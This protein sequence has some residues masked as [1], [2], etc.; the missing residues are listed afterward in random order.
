MTTHIYDRQQGLFCDMNE[1]LKIY[2]N[3]CMTNSPINIDISYEFYPYK[4]DPALNSYDHLFSI[5][6]PK[7]EFIED[8]SSIKPPDK[9]R[10]YHPTRNATHRQRHELF[11]KGFVFNPLITK[12]TTE[13]LNRMKNKH[14]IGVHSRFHSNKRG[15]APSQVLHPEDYMNLLSPEVLISQIYEY[16]TKNDISDND[17]VV[18]L[19]TDLQ[20]TQETFKKEFPHNLVINENNQWISKD[21]EGMKDEPHFGW[22]E[23]DNAMRERFHREK[24]GTRGGQEL[25]VDV[26]VLSKCDVFFGSR[27][28]QMTEWVYNLN[29]DLLTDEDL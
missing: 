27:G 24:P 14:I 7:T 15:A 26:S 16:I 25:L 13:L 10:H 2:Y 29:P 18:F 5:N 3:C 12:K 19:A 17:F 21:L 20:S 28:S 6:Q 1:L 23:K 9:H 8:I 4:D 11:V 22:N